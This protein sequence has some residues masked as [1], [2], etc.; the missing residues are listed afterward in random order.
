SLGLRMNRAASHVAPVPSAFFCSFTQM[1][2][3]LT[4]HFES[5]DSEGARAS[6]PKNFAISLYSHC[7]YLPA[8]VWR[9]FWHCCSAVPLARAIDAVSRTAATMRVRAVTTGVRMR[10]AGLLE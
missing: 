3:Y 7:A 2:V 4:R 1:S 5:A 9:L 10:M 6:P 8:A